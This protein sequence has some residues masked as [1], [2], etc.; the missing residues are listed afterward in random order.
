MKKLLLTVGLTLFL[1]L[2][3]LIAVLSIT[4]YETDKFNKLISEKINENNRNITLNLDKIKFRIDIKEVSLFLET[5]NPKLRY[6][7]LL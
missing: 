2:S 7:N 6:H 1:I 5:K 3:V 4:G